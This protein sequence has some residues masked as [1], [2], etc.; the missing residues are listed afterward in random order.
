MK[1]QKPLQNIIE[2]TIKAVMNT[3]GDCIHFVFRFPFRNKRLHYWLEENI[4]SSH[5]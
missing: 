3:T 5:S 4:Y 2:V 1:L